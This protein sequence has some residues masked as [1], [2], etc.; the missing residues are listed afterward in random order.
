MLR[1]ARGEGSVRKIVDE[2]GRVVWEAS[3]KLPP[4]GDGLQRKRRAERRTQALALAAL[5]G[6]D[7]T[8]AGQPQCAN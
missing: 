6:G 7:A 5:R 2:N 8:R 3:I 4:M 1:P